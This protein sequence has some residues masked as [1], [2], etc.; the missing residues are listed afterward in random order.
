MS[1][2]FKQHHSFERRVLE[3]TRIRKL[4]PD[5]I[6]IVCE[7]SQNQILLPHMDKVKYLVPYDITVSQF[8][9]VIRKRLSLKP[10]VTL[11]VSVDNGIVPSSV[12]TIAELYSA[13]KNAD[14]FLY[15]NYYQENTFGYCEKRF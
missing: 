14:G 4:H 10:E 12:T 3:S 2:T 5:R 8:L 1:I 9:T 11:T 7:K 6:P 13:H 15:F